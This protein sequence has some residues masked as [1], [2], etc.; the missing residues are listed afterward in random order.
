M[1][2]IILDYYT[3]KIKVDYSKIFVITEFGGSY[4][5][6]DCHRKISRII[7]EAI[8]DKILQMDNSPFTLYTGGPL[9]SINAS[10]I[11]TIVNLY[12]KQYQT[13]YTIPDD[14]RLYWEVS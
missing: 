8:L 3:P 4:P 1:K 12:N 2:P 9:V 6:P 5:M 7:D 10:K 14:V 11:N 13:N